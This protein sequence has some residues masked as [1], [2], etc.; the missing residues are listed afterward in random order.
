MFF[1]NLLGILF[2]LG[3]EEEGDGGAEIDPNG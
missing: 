1:W 3:E 2:G